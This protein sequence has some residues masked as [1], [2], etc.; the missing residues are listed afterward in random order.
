MRFAGLVWRHI[1][2]A[3]H[4]LD[5]S[6]LISAAGRW[7]RRG[8]YGCLYTARTPAGAAAEYRKHFVR[9]GLRRDRDLVCLA[10]EIAHVLDLSAVLGSGSRADAPHFLGTANA[11]IGDRQSLLPPIDG[12]RLVGD[13]AD[14]V[15]HCRTIADWARRHGYLA[16]Q[17]PSASVVGEYTIAIYPENRPNELRIAVHADPLPLNY[18]EDP[19]VDGAGVPRRDQP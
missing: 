14:D 1:P 3:A 7:N 10:V 4:P 13:G 11:G 12:D 6:A 18:G 2:R 16:I 5:F 19:F 9:R 8:L 17:A 15:E